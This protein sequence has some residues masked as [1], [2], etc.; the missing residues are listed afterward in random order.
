MHS[1]RTA[2]D[3][4][5]GYVPNFS[6]VAGVPMLYQA[7]C[8]WRRGERRSSKVPAL[9]LAN[10]GADTV[11]VSERSDGEHGQSRQLQWTASATNLCADP[12]EAGSTGAALGNPGVTLG[13][14]VS[15]VS[16]PGLHYGR[17]TATLQQPCL[18]RIFTHTTCRRS[19]PADETD[20]RVTRAQLSSDGGDSLTPRKP[21]G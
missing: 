12:W 16:C 4:A 5:A 17:V 11:Y 1:H 3:A 8:A 14:A 13:T 21:V 19:A 15:P 20:S 9:A 18:L 6:R 2:L 10:A 7:T